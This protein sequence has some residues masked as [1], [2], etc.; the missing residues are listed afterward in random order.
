MGVVEV[1]CGWFIW[2]Q[3]I[4]ESSEKETWESIRAKGKNCGNALVSWEDDSFGF[5]IVTEQRLQLWWR[6]SPHSPMWWASTQCFLI[7][8]RG[9]FEEHQLGLNL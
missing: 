7:H 8:G 4:E 2:R 5:S 1:E 6:Y 3:S 9:V